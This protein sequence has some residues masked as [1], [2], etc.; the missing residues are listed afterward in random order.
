MSRSNGQRILLFRR[1]V[2]DIR[3]HEGHS[4][5]LA[6]SNNMFKLLSILNDFLC[7]LHPIEDYEVKLNDCQGKLFSW[8]AQLPKHCQYP[9][10]VTAENEPE[11]LPS[12]ANLQLTAEAAS[13]FLLARRDMS[14]DKVTQP[15]TSSES[16]PVSVYKT[17]YQEAFGSAAGAA[18]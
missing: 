1:V 15:W 18:S 9:T 11:V 12:V 16:F 5:H 14:T 7:D 10:T 8:K 6:L 17:A 4:E 3:F 2:I 13:R